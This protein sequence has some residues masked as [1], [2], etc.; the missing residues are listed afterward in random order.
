MVFDPNGVQQGLPQSFLRF[1][2]FQEM[3]RGQSVAIDLKSLAKAVGTTPSPH[4]ESISALIARWRSRPF[5]PFLIARRR[6]VAFLWRT[7]FAYLDNLLAWADSLYRRDTRETV[8]EAA[9]LYILAARI[10]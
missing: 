10:L 5:R 1:R 6:H 8:A 9:Q 3:P 7:V 4:I 2:V